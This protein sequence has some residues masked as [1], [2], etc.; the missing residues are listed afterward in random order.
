MVSSPF[1]SLGKE[2][3]GDTEMK[4]IRAGD[5]EAQ[6]VTSNVLRGKVTSQ[7]IIGKSSEELAVTVVNFG[8]GTVR[9]LNAHTFDQVLYVTEGRGIIATETEEVTVTPGTFVFIPAG[10]KHRHSATR[11]SVF[12]HITI[13]IS[14]GKLAPGG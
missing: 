13:R 2:V 5:I 7:D 11:D 10:E 9:G 12:S 8:K 3:E 4:V 14:Q 1:N 6:E